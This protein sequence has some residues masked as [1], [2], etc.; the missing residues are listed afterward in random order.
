VTA[1]ATGPDERGLPRAPQEGEIDGIAYGEWPGREPAVLLAHGISANHRVH[2]H[3]APLLAPRRVVAIDMRGRG[4]SRRDGP[5]GLEAHARDLLTVADALALERPL[6]GGHSLGAYAA[7]VAAAQEPSRVSGLALLDGGVWLPWAVPEAMLRPLLATS[8]ARLDQSFP[9]LDAYAAYWQ[10]SAL[11]LADTPERRAQLARDLVGH[12][13][14]YRPVTAREAF[15]ADF[16][17][18][19]RHPVGN[20]LWRDLDLP[21][22]LVRAGLGMLR[23]S[24]SMLVPDAALRVARTLAPQL[25]V[26]DLPHA[27]HFDMLDP[28]HV[29]A[30]ADELERLGA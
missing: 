17:A 28:P 29:A 16:M 10:R 25:R 3:L 18:V 2:L 12:P 23:T 19:A 7:L 6:L 13:G 4:R 5:F 21:A 1:T 9:D 24:S 8:I 30:V 22:L 26:L 11:A 14:D 27:D 20:E 15:D